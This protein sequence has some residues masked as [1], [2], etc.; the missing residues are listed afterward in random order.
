MRRWWWT[1]KGVCWASDKPALGLFSGGDNRPRAA[2][3]LLSH[4]GPGA[5]W[6]DPRP[7]RPAQMH[8]Q[9]GQRIYQVTCSRAALP[10]ERSGDLCH[11]LF[12]RWLKREAAAKPYPRNC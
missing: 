6:W 8:V 4:P 12:C 5:R 7:E 1:H 3:R 2:S 11:R 10:G 9:L